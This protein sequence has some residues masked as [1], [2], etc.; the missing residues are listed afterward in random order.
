[1]WDGF[2]TAFQYGI[3]WSEDLSGIIMH[4]VRR[5]RLHAMMAPAK[6]VIYVE[7]RGPLTAHEP[8]LAKLKKY[9]T[10]IEDN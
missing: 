6:K 4:T 5:H 3:A 1:M 2:F 9:C 10:L 7:W 8:H